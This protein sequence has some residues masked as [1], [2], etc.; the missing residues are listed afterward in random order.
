MLA[1]TELPGKRKTASLG[2]PDNVE[3]IPVAPESL[4][5]L[6]KEIRDVR[7]G[8]FSIEI[9]KRAQAFTSL[10]PGTIVGP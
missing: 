4:V 2:E 10:P 7:A 3:E 9:E 6:A 8:H 1:H 5:L